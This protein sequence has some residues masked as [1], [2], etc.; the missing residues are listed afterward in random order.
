MV[1]GQK[2]RNILGEISDVGTK[3]LPMAETAATAMACGL[4]VLG[5]ETAR[6]G[7]DI[8]K[9]AISNVDTLY[10]QGR[11]FTASAIFT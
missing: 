5:F 11:L 4:E 7:L 1:F 2:V 9:T 10:N 6:K 8:I 3:L